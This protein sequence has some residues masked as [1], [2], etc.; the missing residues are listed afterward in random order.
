MHN[1]KF[2]LNIRVLREHKSALYALAKCEGES[3][4]VT[5]RKLIKEAA[6]AK[7]VWPVLSES[8]GTTKNYEVSHKLEIPQKRSEG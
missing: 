6:L 8:N 2:L 3:M 7:G 4:S 5:L 1:T